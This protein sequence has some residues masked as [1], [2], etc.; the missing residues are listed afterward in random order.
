[1]ND[2]EKIAAF[3]GAMRRSN[4]LVAGGAQPDC[5]NV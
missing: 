5:H 2:V 4:S 3:T 1:M